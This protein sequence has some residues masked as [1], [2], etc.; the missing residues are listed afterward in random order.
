MFGYVWCLRQLLPAVGGIISDLC[1]IISA[2]KKIMHITLFW[3]SKARLEG[4]Q[5]G[6]VNSTKNQSAATFHM[7]ATYLV[8][9]SPRCISNRIF[10]LLFSLSFP[11]TSTDQWAFYLH[12]KLAKETFF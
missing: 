5:Q 7:V 10:L 4:C 11:V 3:S 9:L 1:Q 2:I 8:P 12:V 6:K